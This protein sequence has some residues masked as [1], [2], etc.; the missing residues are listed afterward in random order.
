MS[1]IEP[2]AAAR[3]PVLY[4]APWVD[5]GGADKGTIDWFR[6][7][8]RDRFAPSLI[9][10]QP[11]HNR[12]LAE[13]VPFAEEAWALPDEMAGHR[14]PGF[15]FDFIQTRQVRLLHIMNSRLG[16]DLLPDLACL[17]NPPAVV[18]QLH[19]EEPNRSGYVRYVTT[20]YG[21]LV[22]AFSVSSQYLAGAVEGYDMPRSKIRV[23]PTGVDAQL[24]FNPNRVR[25]LDDASDQY[26]FRVL[27]AGRLTE[28]KDPLLMLEVARLLAASHHQFRIDV[29]G[30]GPLEGQ[31]RDRVE[32]LGLGRHVRFHPPTRELARWLAS[33]DLLLMTSTFE[34]VPYAIYEAMAMHVPVV[35]PA[36]P[37]NVELLEPGGGCLIE[38]RDRPSAY[39]EAVA[40][41]IDDDS[42][43]VR[44]GAIGRQRVLSSFTLRGMAAAHE[45]LYDELLAD[46]TPP[47]QRLTAPAPPAPLRFPT[48]PTHGTP[49]VSVITPCYNHGRYLSS[50]L[51]G[52]AAQDYPAI[53]LIIV[54]DA[55]EDPDTRVRLEHLEREGSARVLRQSRRG[56]PSAARNRAID[57]A[58]GR[59]ILPVDADNVLLPG[60]VK[61]LVG[62][63]QAAGERVG[64]IYPTAK[65]FGNRDYLFRPPTYNLYA[66]LQ[67]NFADTC[68]LFDREIFEA[69]LRF[70]ED[71]ELGHEDWDLAL[72]LASRDVIGEPS[73][74]TVMLYRK[75]GFT[76]SDLVEYLRLPFWR[77]IGKRHPELFGLPDDVG[78]WGR[79][80]GPGLR[81]KARSS[82]ALSVIATDPV[83]FDGIEGAA[84]T[85]ALLRQTA[86][87]MELIAECQRRPSD[88]GIVVRRLP[89]GL[90]SSVKE[91]IEEALAISRGRYLL[92][93][94]SPA[95]FLSD[96]T[97]VERLL[98]GFLIDTELR[99]IAFLDLGEQTRHPHSLIERSTAALAPHAVVWRRELHGEL[100]GAVEVDD[101]DVVASLARA[102]HESVAQMQWRHFP[103]L[104]RVVSNGR[105]AVGLRQTLVFE[106]RRSPTVLTASAR[107]EREAASSA[108]PAV[109]A[110]RNNQVPRWSGAPAWMPPETMLLVRHVEEGGTRR[111]ITHHRE[112]PFGFRIEFD[113]GAI[114]RFSPPGTVRLIRRDGAFLTLPRG[115]DPGATDEQLGYLEEAPLPLFI[116]I[117]RAVLADGSETLVAATDRDP[118]RG[119]AR[120]LAFLGFIESFPNEPVAGPPYTKGHELPVL[121]RWLDRTHRRHRYAVVTPPSPPQQLGLMSAELGRLRLS[122]DA[123]SIPL[124]SDARGRVL[125]DR[126]APADSPFDVKLALRWAVAPLGWRGFG[127]RYGRLR[128]VARRAVDCEHVLLG[129]ARAA[130]RSTSAGSRATARIE[131]DR[132]YA[133]LLGYL[134]SEAGPGL[135]PLFAATHPVLDDQF[136]THHRL[137]A[138]DMGY[139]DVVRLGY[140][141]AEAPVTGTLG[142]QRV[143]VP[144]A[145]RFGLSARRL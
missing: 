118:V 2:S 76:R 10:T 28:Q 36:L 49:L 13:V 40:A 128:S 54:D 47:S 8:N 84:L 15:I 82:P 90:S 131:S 102:I 87:D 46:R 41:L 116:G 1:V 55:S 12:R 113:L 136:L 109:P 50:L 95:E 96:P 77:E 73:R 141:G 110:A 92:I 67:G 106:R 74:A 42:A 3:V 45:S 34:G 117:E 145:S 103:L 135:A 14:F 20:R 132:D 97:V 143:S 21:N 57:A 127:H 62:Q 53:E 70:A 69:G 114:Q 134:H 86:R 107:I 56:G 94:R 140:V 120:E 93:S 119:Q 115:S 137:E 37:G 24:E 32:E 88:P 58:R 111:V 51:E 26:E 66:L 83:D 81:I 99:A 4:L 11:S 139:V 138:S 126:Y 39:A 6:W 31:V 123:D 60:A 85:R 130:A 9:T 78:A 124:F 17:D 144:W 112:P 142:S 16:Y 104:S 22:D 23:I 64:F 79:W 38:P 65:Y 25:P 72:A 30:D 5:F 44:M 80:R 63:L 105:G 68:S 75:H 129:R 52:V 27:F 33:S 35:A 108:T 43:R 122:P 19:V 71:I 100:G 101:G 89:P 61:S 29:V 48:R 98:R 91:R 18:V 121:L 133:R 125:T 7:L 59:Y